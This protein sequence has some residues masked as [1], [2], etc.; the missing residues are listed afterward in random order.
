VSTAP[1]SGPVANGVNPGRVAAA[2]S[3]ARSA[4]A[5]TYFRRVKVS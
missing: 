4:I 5:G 2:T 3:A 1:P